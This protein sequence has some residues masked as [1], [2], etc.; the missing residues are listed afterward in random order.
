[1]HQHPMRNKPKHAHP[2]YP[3]V[4]LQRKKVQE[5]KRADTACQFSSIKGRKMASWTHITHLMHSLTSLNMYSTS[6]RNSNLTKSIKSHTTLN[7]YSRGKIV[8]TNTQGVET[9]NMGSVCSFM[10]LAEHLSHGWSLGPD[11]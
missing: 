7:V 6:V 9:I 4:M 11:F 10:A 8:L 2:H 5:R 3:V 1:M